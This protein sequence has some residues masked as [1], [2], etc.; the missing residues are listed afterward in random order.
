MRA[1]VDQYYGQIQD[2]VYGDHT[3]LRNRWFFSHD[4]IDLQEQLFVDFAL[5]YPSPMLS[6]LRRLKFKGSL[7]YGDFVRLERFSKLEVLEIGCLEFN[8]LAQT[9]N[10]PNLRF[11]CVL[12]IC[13]PS[14]LGRYLINSSHVVAVYFGEHF[15]RR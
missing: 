4:L 8:S 7:R 14:K 11:F 5:T 6:E 15:D 12:S 9:V 10:L 1:F 2:I 3:L 13:R